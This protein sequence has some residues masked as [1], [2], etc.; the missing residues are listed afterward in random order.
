MS[1]LLALLLVFA[2]PHLHGIVLDKYSGAPLHGASVRVAGT[3]F[4]AITDAQ[5]E[6]HIHDVRGDSVTL[7]VS[8][9]G[10]TTTY[11]RVSTLGDRATEIRLTTDTLTTRSILVEGSAVN[12]VSLPTQRTTTLSNEQLDAT[13]TAS[14]AGSLEQVPGVTVMATG[15]SIVKPVIHGLSGQRIVVSQA[16]VNQEGQQWGEEHAPEIDPFTPS[17]IT[18]L[19]G[20][21]GVRAGPNAMGG[22]IAIDPLPLSN[23]SATTRGEAS[24]NLFANNL[25]GALGGWLESTNIADLPVAVRVFGAARKA[26]DARTPNYVLG[27][28]AFASWSAGLTS[29]IGSEKT[30]VRIHGS[31]FNTSLGIYAGS[32][33]GN[34][35]DLQRAID[36]G[37]PL[38]EYSFSYDIDRPRQEVAHML[39]SIKAFTALSDNSTLTLNYGWQQNNRSEFDRHGRTTTQDKPAMNLLLTTYDLGLTLDHTLGDDWTGAAGLSVQRQVN[40]RSGTVY[41]VPDYVQ[42]GFGAWWYESVSI[43]QATLSGGLRYDMRVLDAEITSRGTDVVSYQQK[44]YSGLSGILGAKWLPSDDWQL[45]ANAG[46]A[47]RPPQINELY[48]NDVHHG[49]AR[50]V[51]G[52]STLAPERSVNLDVT[53]VWAI[54]GIEIEASAYAMFFSNYIYSVPD[55]ASPTV[56]IRGTFPTFEFVQTQA[57]IAG[58]DLSAAV[59]LSDIYSV[60]TKGALVFGDDVS[61]PSTPLIFMP[62]NRLRIG[63]HIHTHDVIGIHDTYIDISVNLVDEQHRTTDGQDLAPPPQGYGTTR[64]NLGGIID[65][66]G[67]AARLALTIENVFNIAYRDYLSRYRYFADDPGRDVI[68]RFTIPFG[69]S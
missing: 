58:L 68:L 52:D 14:I 13:R 61:S 53:A 56:T 31:L 59:D 47:W 45:Y 48:S 57:R 15:P 64:L 55:P 66:G 21:S 17:T 30:G 35:T 4:G 39:L 20:A 43:G 36:A 28:T 27:N 24:I 49:V 69:D 46:L 8:M 33:V 67:R 42:Q 38:Q 10:R 22:A 62:A 23:S 7:V 9:V 63:A 37:S 65:I 5:G 19:K 11:V 41:L 34:P 25:Q 51:I 50:Y 12:S 2:D 18:L 44:T 16:G 3:R 1:V 26:G 32:H 54:P 29:L 6:F 40:D 60:Y